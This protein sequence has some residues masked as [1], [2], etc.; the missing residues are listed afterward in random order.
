MTPI[1]E[2]EPSPTGK[3]SDRLVVRF[4]GVDIAAQGRVAM[5]AL[6]LL[7]CGM[8]AGIALLV[9]LDASA[10]TRA[11]WNTVFIALATL[12]LGF[13]SASTVYQYYRSRE[14]AAL[15]AQ[16]DSLRVRADALLQKFDAYEKGQL[17]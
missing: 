15:N 17:R 4:Y 13:G 1:S 12:C 2:N 10:P 11:D 8:L 7:V 3:T 16:Y 9:V 5:L 6:A 14:S